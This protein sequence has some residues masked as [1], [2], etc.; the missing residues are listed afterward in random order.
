MLS[1]KF[2]R[3][4]IWLGTLSFVGWFGADPVRFFFPVLLNP[5]TDLSFKG[6]GLPLG[7]K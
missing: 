7:N 5:Y 3:W 1:K 6:L 2:S 4:K